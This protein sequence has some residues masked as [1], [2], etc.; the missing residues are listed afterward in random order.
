MVQILCPSIIQIF[1]PISFPQLLIVFLV[2]PYILMEPLKTLSLLFHMLMILIYQPHIKS[3]KVLHHIG[4]LT[5][6]SHHNF[7]AIQGFA[8]EINYLIFCTIRK[9][10]CTD[11]FSITDYVC[12]PEFDSRNKHSDNSPTSSVDKITKSLSTSF[13]QILHFSTLSWSS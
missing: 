1:T 5:C 2:Q 10:V 6:D 13:L 9:G 7:A 12:R 8:C 3:R 4:R 11:L